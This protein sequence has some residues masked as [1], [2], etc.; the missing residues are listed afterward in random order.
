MSAP[1]LSGIAALIKSKHPEWS[2]AAI[3]S[4]IMTSAD[5]TDRFGKPI[6]NEQLSPADLF[7]IGAGHVNPEKA[8]NPGLVYDIT[9]ADYIGFLCGLYTSKE[10]SVIA[11]KG[12]DC[13]AIKVI[14]E[15]LLNYPSITVMLPP[16]WNSTIPMLVECTV[17]NVGEVPIVYY[18]QF[19]LQ[20]NAMNISVVPASLRFNDVNQVKTYTVIVWPKTCKTSVVVQGALRWVSDKYTVRSPISVAFA[21]Q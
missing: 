4:A 11:R 18:P 9:P 3:K 1:H 21:G 5:I 2:P 8:M 16:S 17:T 19:D 14:P 15:H 10:V 20:D 6:L 13:S 12:V 7:A